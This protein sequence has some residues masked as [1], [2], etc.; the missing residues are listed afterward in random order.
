MQNL[1]ETDVL[2][3]G[4]G[5]CGLFQVFQLGLQGIACHVV[6]ALPHPGG[7]CTELYAEKPIYDIPGIPR[8]LAGELTTRLLQQLKPFNP[9]FHYQQTVVEVTRS[10]QQQFTA[11]TGSG[12]TF[13]ANNIVLAAGAGAF[14]Q[15]KMRVDDIDTFENRQL[16]YQK[17][18]ENFDDNK[19]NGR[20]V[21]V[22]G[23]TQE[24][25]DTAIRTC[26]S[27]AKTTYIH[28]KRR[29]AAAGPELALL[30]QLADEKS[31]LLLNGKITGMVTNQTN[32]KITHLQ[33]LDNKKES[34]QIAVDLIVA[35]LG[36]APKLN[37]FGDWQLATTRHHVDVEPAGF[38]SNLPGFYVI[39]DIN[40]Y[41]GKRKLIL[42]GFHE[43]TLAAFAIAAKRNPDK[44]VHTQY[45]TTSTDLLKRLGVAP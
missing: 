45:T 32:D 30:Q 3:I 7:Q 41:P 1:I 8:V 38:E 33:L 24:A 13:R 12:L 31:M 39:G 4:A 17:L 9:V 35:C 42:C 6:E 21:V 22:T 44:P 27:G 5:P 26:Q 19:L 16:F 34:Q 28:R 40:H 15:V 14:K 37:A 20:Q 23:D 18:P 25:I 11:T 29:L 10:G 43:A 36:S 2:V